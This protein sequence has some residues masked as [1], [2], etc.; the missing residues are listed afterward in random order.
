MRLA[1]PL[2][3]HNEASSLFKVIEQFVGREDWGIAY[4]EIGLSRF[5]G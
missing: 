5:I 4:T 3:Y 1:A 2:A